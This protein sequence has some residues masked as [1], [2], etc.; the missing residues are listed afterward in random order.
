[1]TRPDWWSTRYESVGP[2]AKAWAAWLHYGLGLSFAKCARLLARLG[3]DVS[4]GAL[5]QAA[6]STGT[7]LVPVQTEIVERVNH[8]EAVV[9]DETGWRVG[10]GSAWLW[11]ATTNEATAYN[12]ADG[13]GFEQ[14]CH[15]VEEDY[16]GVIVRDAWAPYRRYGAASHQTC[17]AHLLRRCDELIT[18][19]PGW[20]RARLDWSKTCSS[21]PWPLV[22]MGL[23]GEQL[24]PFRQI[25]D[26]RLPAGLV[27]VTRRMPS[28]SAISPTSSP[29]CSPSWP[30]P[31]WMPPTGR[32]SKPS[33][34]PW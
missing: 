30:A 25:G 4:A 7:D 23:L 18:D 29:R 15:L 22:R 32:P 31:T 34:P 16:D 6:Q 12:L 13:R 17:V 11:T 27:K 21:K 20:A 10:G 9:M 3:I 28:S 24:D 1:M 26:G 5:C 2:V 8:A 33:A 14:A 19:L